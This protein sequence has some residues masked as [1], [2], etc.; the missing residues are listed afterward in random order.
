MLSVKEDQSGLLN[1]IKEKKNEKE[2]LKSI[3]EGQEWDQTDNESVNEFYYAHAAEQ[4]FGV[5]RQTEMD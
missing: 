1:E 4:A 3:Y 5:V 2:K